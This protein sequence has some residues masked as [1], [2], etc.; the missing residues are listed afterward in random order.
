MVQEHVFQTSSLGWEVY[1]FLAILTFIMEF[2]F[3]VVAYHWPTFARLC[4]KV[5]NFVTA[6]YRWR[7]CGVSCPDVPK[8]QLK[9]VQ[10]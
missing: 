9:K 1:T 8:L 5:L 4:H 10:N 3:A 2:I 7:K 6:L